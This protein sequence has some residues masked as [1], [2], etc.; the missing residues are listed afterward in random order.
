[1]AQ[2]PRHNLSIGF[3]ME[4]QAVFKKHPDL[5]VLRPVAKAGNDGV[6]PLTPHHA[7]LFM[8]HFLQD[9]LPA[10]M[11]LVALRG[12]HIVTAQ[13]DGSC[14]W[15][16]TDKT[17]YV[18]KHEPDIDSMPSPKGATYTFPLEITTPAFNDVDEASATSWTKEI[19]DLMGGLHALERETDMELRTSPPR[20]GLHVHIGPGH[21]TDSIKFDLEELKKIA[22]VVCVF[23]E[24]IQA[25][26]PR[27]R[28][29]ST[30][31]K[32][33]FG[34]ATSQILVEESEISDAII[35]LQDLSKFVN[36]LN[37]YDKSYQVNFRRMLRSK[38]EDAT[39][40]FRQ[41][42]STND[43]DMICLWGRF[44]LALVRGSLRTNWD[45]ENEITFQSIIGDQ[46]LLEQLRGHVVTTSRSRT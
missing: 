14:P 38:P 46:E 21:N 37:P 26:I 2:T 13:Y 43:A 3:E 27:S 20:T 22:I 41:Q 6:I 44:V 42:A 45:G 23:T 10:E 15:N 31:L 28:H 32:P 18:F 9:R 16:V 17:H 5:S 40:E 8:I 30:A 11:K 7:R 4:F 29:L 39:V 12:N 25:Y 34:T 35:T 33:M 36:T 1:M 24:N 19:R